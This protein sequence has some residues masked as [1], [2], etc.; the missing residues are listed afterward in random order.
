MHDPRKLAK[1]DAVVANAAHPPR[2]DRHSQVLDVLAKFRYVFRSSR[3]HARRVEQHCSVSGAQL[4]ALWEL[5]HHPGMRISDVARAMAIHQS[6]ASNML[7][8]LEGRALVRRERGKPDHRVVQVYLTRAGEEVLAL[9]PAPARGVLNDALDGMPRGSLQQ[10][11]T[12]LG[13]VVR[14]IRR[15]N[16]ADAGEIPSER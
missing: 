11:D 12:L 8:K 15:H 3:K 7:D 6:T 4:W 5:K 14:A 13:Q 9:A 2:D 10:L 1:P 16:D